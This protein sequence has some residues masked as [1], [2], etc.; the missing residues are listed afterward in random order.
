MLLMVD[1][2]IREGV[3]HSLYQYAKA[4]S[5]YIKIYNENKE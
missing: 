4:N 2:S 5:K 3:C 1:K